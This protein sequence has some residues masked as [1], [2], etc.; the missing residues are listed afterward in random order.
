M[1]CYIYLEGCHLGQ[2]LPILV[3]DTWDKTYRI[4]KTAETQAKK[5]AGNQ[6]CHVLVHFPWKLLT[7]K[8]LSP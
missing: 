7:K 2:A 6:P 1:K 4:R 5:K 3:R 8:L